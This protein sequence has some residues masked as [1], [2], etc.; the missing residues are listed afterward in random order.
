MAASLIEA[1]NGSSER[2]AQ[3]CRNASSGV[4]V[5]AE[6]PPLGR[7]RG[8]GVN[9]NTALE[10]WGWLDDE[11]C[12][13]AYHLSSRR[14]WGG[15]EASVEFNTTEVL[16]FLRHLHPSPHIHAV[17]APAPFHI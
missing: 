8:W 1:V 14:R 10:D 11:I 16:G 6:L 3:L 12:G 9:V 5:D 15:R 13:F 17:H 4:G 2:V 7:T